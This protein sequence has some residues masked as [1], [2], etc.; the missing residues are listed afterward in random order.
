MSLVW[1]LL[2]TI[3]SYMEKKRHFRP[4]AQ[5]LEENSDGAHEAASIASPLT[6]PESIR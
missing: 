2:T 3:P 1:R 4:L 6:S 5:Y